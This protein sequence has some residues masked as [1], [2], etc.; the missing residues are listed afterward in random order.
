MTI[1]T[2]RDGTRRHEAEGDPY[3]RVEYRRLIGWT[4]RIRREGPWLLDL[5]D[6]APERSVLDLG[7]GTGEHTAFFA[8]HGAR[9]VGVD[10]SESMLAAAREHEAG[11]RGRFVHGDIRSVDGLLG[12]EPGFGMAV[13]LGNVL[14]HLTGEDDL[15]A[16]F[17]AVARLLLPGGRFLIQLLNYDRII[18]Q[19]VRHLPLNFREGDD[20]E[21]IVFLRLMKPAPDG[22][23]L[24]F[25]TT[26]SL[27]PSSEAPVS[28][29]GSQRV[30]LRGWTSGA[31]EAAL[32]RADFSV[33]LGGDMMGGPFDPESSNDLVVLATRHRPAEPS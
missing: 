22:R 15:E 16:F 24:F 9:A 12:A 11:G 28:V 6:G 2:D 7:P 25:P 18:G 3:S 20:G 23:I 27:D 21:E 31:V 5:L 4:E 26:L 33:V 32:E 10:R 1:R 19:N 14:P 30:E 13:C 8:E 29:S 17:K